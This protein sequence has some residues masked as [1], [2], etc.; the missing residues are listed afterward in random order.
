MGDTFKPENWQQLQDV[1]SWAIQEKAPLEILGSGSKQ[2]LGHAVQAEHSLSLAGFQGISLYEPEELVL[3]ARAGTSLAEIKSALG[4]SRQELAF[5]PLDLGPLYGQPAGGGT[6][7]GTIACNLAGPRRIKTGAARD[8]FLGF[9]C[10]T[11]RGEEIKSGARVVK[12]VT[13][14][15]LSK[16]M[17]GSYGTLAVMGEVTLKVLP[18]AEKSYTVMVLGQD[19]AAAVKAMSQ[20]LNSPYD[21]SGAAYL[22]AEAAAHSEVSYVREAGRA[23]TF[24]RLEGTSL[25]VKD[26]CRSLRDELSD[27]GETEELHTHNSRLFWDE[28][29]RINPLCQDQETAVWRLSVAPTQAPKVADLLASVPNALYYADWGG[30]LLWIALPPEGDAGASLLRGAVAELG[31]H[32]TLM[33]ADATLREQVPV[34]QPMDAGLELLSQRLRQSFDPMQLFNRGRLSLKID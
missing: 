4:Q 28:L 10:V 19:I 29:S 11:G 18:A 27:F 7:A 8:H 1:V 15:D 16:I 13:G 33:R 34:F 26:R 24:L 14:Y 25:S 22:P 30:G 3:S 9:R 23:V 31:G 20:G 17:A 32:A 6:L 5:E 21:I 2:A 12:N